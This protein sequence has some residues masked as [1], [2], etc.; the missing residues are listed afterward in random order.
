MKCKKD[1]QGEKEYCTNNQDAFLQLLH[2]D[3]LETKEE[4]TII[5]TTK[6]MLM[7]IFFLSIS[8]RSRIYEISIQRKCRLFSKRCLSDAEISKQEL[9]VQRDKEVKI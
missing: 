3:E 5:M 7:L 4:M 2:Y 6:R 1:P 9:S 8:C